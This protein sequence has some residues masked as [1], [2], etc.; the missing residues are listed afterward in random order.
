MMAE[1]TDA[2]NT[3]GALI[4]AA[5]ALLPKLAMVAYGIT[6]LASRL[7]PPNAP[8]LWAKLHK[9]I[10]LIAFNVGYAGNK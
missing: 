3:L 6:A 2:L 10:N 9:I 8:G 1:A 4:D 5:Q 7:P